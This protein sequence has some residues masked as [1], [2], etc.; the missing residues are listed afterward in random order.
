MGKIERLLTYLIIMIL[1]G[2]LVFSNKKNPVPEAGLNPATSSYHHSYEQKEKW[3]SLDNEIS[4]PEPWPG[5]KI[6][7]GLPYRIVDGEISDEVP[8]RVWVRYTV[9]VSKNDAV[10][11]GQDGVKNLLFEL[12]SKT[13]TWIDQNYSKEKWRE[14]H[15]FVTIPGIYGCIAILDK[16]DYPHSSPPHIDF[17]FWK[18]IEQ[19]K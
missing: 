6:E 11:V 12:F 18:N 9:V 13:S 14:I 4:L 10:D 7:A 2:F 8:A 17:S 15:I 19:L 3:Y 1:L 16:P 5:E